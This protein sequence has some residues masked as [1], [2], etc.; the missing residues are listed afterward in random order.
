MGEGLCGVRF[1]VEQRRDWHEMVV[2]EVQEREEMAA[3]ERERPRRCASELQ[4]QPC[5]V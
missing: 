4:T 2:E 1:P 5:E 3:R